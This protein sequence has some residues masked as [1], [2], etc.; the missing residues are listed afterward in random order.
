VSARPINN[1][2][3][4]VVEPAAEFCRDVQNAA[5]GR[6]NARQISGLRPRADRI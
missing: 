5:A 4:K 1:R 2:P 6:D 3:A